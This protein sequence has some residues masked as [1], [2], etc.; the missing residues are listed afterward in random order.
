MAFFLYLALEPKPY[1][2][3]SDCKIKPLIPT[4][5]KVMFLK[6]V[7]YIL[8]AR[9]TWIFSPLH[10]K[11]ILDIAKLCFY[12]LHQKMVG[13]LFG[14]INN[15]VKG[16]VQECWCALSQYRGNLLYLSKALT[17]FGIS[18]F[19]LCA[20]YSHKWWV[21]FC[22]KIQT[23]DNFNK[24]IFMTRKFFTKSIFYSPSNTFLALGGG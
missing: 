8:H 3:C 9:S 10:F 12:F 22:C 16:N 1:I 13:F 7:F 21:F 14:R 2:W 4:R 6:D 11:G 18:L 5:L 19:L 17:K 23:P 24:K 15:M 20:K